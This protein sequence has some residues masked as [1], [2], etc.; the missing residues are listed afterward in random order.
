M[1]CYKS[2]ITLSLALMMVVSMMVFPAFAADITAD[3][4]DGVETVLPGSSGGENSIMPLDNTDSN[5]IVLSV[6]AANSTWK[7]GQKRVKENNSCIYFW[8]RIFGETY[9]RVRASGYVTNTVSS[10]A[11]NCTTLKN[12]TS[13]SYVTCRIGQEYL[14]YNTIH[15]NRFTYAGLEFTRNT[16]VS[17]P[18]N[19]EYTWSPDS[20]GNYTPAT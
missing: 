15:E 10:K 4:V 17:T 6:P 7:A 5:Y 20:V 16:T 2:I 1:K 18:T 14:I 12:G 11:T 19:L 9:V 3:S 13:V 8:G